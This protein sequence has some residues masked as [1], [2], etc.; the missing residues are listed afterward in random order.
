MIIKGN[1]ILVNIIG[2]G[3]HPAERFFNYHLP[4]YNVY[5]DIDMY[6]IMKYKTIYNGIAFVPVEAEKKQVEAQKAKT[7]PESVKKHEIT[8]NDSAAEEEKDIKK[9]TPDIILKDVY[10]KE[11][12]QKLGK[13][14]IA[15]ILIR[16]GHNRYSRGG[17]GHDPMSPNNR[18][19]KAALI[20]K[21]LK[22]NKISE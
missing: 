16:R 20:A 9:E 14:D 21:V 19:D 22:T 1:K 11:E 7:V 12:L 4:A 17:R 5:I 2:V 8:L 13:K 6:D 15:D 18:N 3:S 10:T